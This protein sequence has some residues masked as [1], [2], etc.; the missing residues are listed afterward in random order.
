SEFILEKMKPGDIHTHN[1]A[2]HICVLQQNGKLHPDI[3]KAQRQG[4]I[5]DVGHGGGSLVWRNAV[6]AIKQG[7]LPNSLSTDLHA[8]SVKGAMVNMVNVMSKFLNV[9][10]TLEQVIERSTI[11]P[12][13]EINHPELGNLSVGST[14]DIAILKLEKG[15]YTFLDTS[16]GKIKGN[17]KLENYITVYGG[18]IVFDPYGISY[19]NWEEIP[20]DDQY[21]E[22]ISKQYY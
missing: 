13:R 11:N 12:A 7:F 9:G 10:L 21:W 2:R 5:F 17:K 20:K 1:Y 18:R 14:A 19:P 4:K 8:G 15:K 3:L 22:N 6:P 16:G